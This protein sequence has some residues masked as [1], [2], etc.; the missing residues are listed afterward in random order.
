MLFDARPLPNSAQVMP[1]CEIVRAVDKS[2]HTLQFSYMTFSQ[3]VIV[4][5]H[6]LAARDNRPAHVFRHQ[7]EGDSESELKLNCS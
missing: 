6:L 1:A 3:E 7:N 5:A 2:L 4:I